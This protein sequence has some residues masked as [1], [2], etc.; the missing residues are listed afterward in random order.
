VLREAGLS[1]GEI[2]A[3]AASGATI[4][5]GAKAQAAE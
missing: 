4:D 3:L 5:S 1:D 2:K